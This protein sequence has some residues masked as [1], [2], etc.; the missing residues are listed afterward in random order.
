MSDDAP[1]TRYITCVLCEAMCGL[2]VQ[3]Q[4]TQI[5]SMRGHEADPL[6]RGHICPKA[7]ALQDLHED[8]DRLRQPVRRVGEEWVTID[9]PEAIELVADRLSAIQTEHGRDA[10]AVYLGNPNVH[11]LGAL[12]HGVSFVRAIKSKN[13]YSATSVDQLPHQLMSLL[14]YGHQFLIPIPD[15]DKT[16]YFLVL[17]GNPMA[18]NGS[19][20][21]VPD[22]PGRLRE[23]KARGGR[24]VV[25]DPRRTETAKVAD[26]HHFV[27]PGTDALLLLAMLNVLFA[28]HLTRPAAYV[29]G[30]ETVQE[31]VTDFTPEAVESVC[32]VPADVIRRTARDFA[33]ARAAAAYGRLGVSTQAFGSLCQ[34]AIHALN[35]LTGNLDREGGVCF[36]TPAIDLVGRGILGKGH[37][38]AWRSRVRGLPE[39]G[40][41]LPVATLAEEIT[42]PGVGQV[43]ALVTMA[44]NP[45]SST[46]GGQHLD[47]ALAGLDFMVS[48]D[49]YVNETTRHAD[50]ILPPTGP[51]ERDHYDLIFHAFAVRNTARFSSAL[52]GRPDDARHDWEIYRD[53]ALALA[54][55]SRRANGSNVIGAIK[56]LPDRVATEA[57]LR[58]SPAQQIDALLRLSPAG[59]SVKQL[60]ATPGGRDLGP[61]VEGQLPDR[62]Q[63]DTHLVDLASPIVLDDLPRAKELL[64][65]GDS[66][67]LEQGRDLLLVGRRHQRDN[68]SWLHNQVRLTKGRPRHQLLAHPDDLAARGIQG[69]EY[70]RVASAAGSVDVEVAASD[71][72]MVGVVSL[73]HGYGHNRKGV[74]LGNATALPGASVNDLTDPK[75]VDRVGANAVMNGVPV[76]LARAEQP[77]P[78]S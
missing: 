70:V 30:V 19:I 53:L 48:V 12:T 7:F 78:T 27:R 43:R 13:T 51:L 29:R 77:V 16:A 57:R 25:F 46:P 34:W 62:L 28:E 4:G 50:V 36:P 71:D 17:G 49:F 32:R 21:T 38:G 23:L 39:F 47:A 15:I 55:R 37:L 64:A 5:V 2:E 69:G 24:M 9:W 41:E 63:N 18:S 58:L 22:F 54:D 65:Q 72:M 56:D 26:E 3:L 60:A 40:G 61:L 31:A 35:A 42:T 20:M 68:N 10:V 6:S 8:L 73:P 74:R 45:V 1:Q 66:A 44:G 11:S 67:A 59:L 33:G 14:L 76:S 52:Y 75:V